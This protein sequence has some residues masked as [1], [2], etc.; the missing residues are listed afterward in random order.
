MHLLVPTEFA[1]GL[2]ERQIPLNPDLLR[3]YEQLIAAGH[4]PDYYSKEFKK[5][6]VKLGLK[7]HRFHDLRHTFG[8]RTWLQTGD[9]MLVS[10]LMGHRNIQTTM[11][12]TRFLPTR[13]AE[14]FPDLTAYLSEHSKG[15]AERLGLNIR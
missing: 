15:R 2:E 3:I 11:I 12:Y 6:L 5:V 9:I 14:D 4:R 1:K 13:L 8:V 10:N 7:G